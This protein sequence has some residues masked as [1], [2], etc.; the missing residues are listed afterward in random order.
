MEQPVKEKDGVRIEGHNYYLKGFPGDGAP[1]I[2]LHHGKPAYWTGKN[3]TI[4]EVS[5]LVLV[6]IALVVMLSMT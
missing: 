3:T 4:A 5:A 2:E 6:I 1:D